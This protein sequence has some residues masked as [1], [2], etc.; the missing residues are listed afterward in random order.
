MIKLPEPDECW[1]PNE[2]HQILLAFQSGQL[3]PKEGVEDERL[4]IKIEDRRIIFR[5]YN[6]GVIAPRI[7]DPRYVHLDIVP[8][9]VLDAFSDLL[10]G[11]DTE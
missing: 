3:V 7:S 1:S 4:Q 5:G 11:L 8:A 10:L 2:V 9:T 6:V